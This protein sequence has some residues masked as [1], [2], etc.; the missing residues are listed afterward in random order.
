MGIPGVGSE[1]ACYCTKCK[2]DLHHVI[3]AMVEERIIKVQCKTCGGV[4]KYRDAEKIRKAPV[5][6][7]SR[8]AGTVTKID[9]PEKIQALWESGMKGANGTE[10]SYK[11]DASYNVG[12]IVVHEVFGKGVVQKIF[13]K[14]ILALFKDKERLLASSNS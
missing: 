9:P 5:A 7:K 2:L 1:I 6:K 3:M 14:R 10:R 12:E 13:T 8:V 11:M 4:H